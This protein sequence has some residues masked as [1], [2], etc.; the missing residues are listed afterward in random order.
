MLPTVRWNQVMRKTNTS[1]GAAASG[2]GD[3]ACFR[4]GGRQIVVITLSDALPT[5]ATIN[6]NPV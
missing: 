1:N 6:R 5:T 4:K 3:T 2:N